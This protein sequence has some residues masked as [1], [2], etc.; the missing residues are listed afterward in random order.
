M[1]TL[2]LALT[3]LYQYLLELGYSAFKQRTGLVYC[4][5]CVT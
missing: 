2:T 5:F 1:L 4:T 3:T